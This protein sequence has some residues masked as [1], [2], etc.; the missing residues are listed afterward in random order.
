MNDPVTPVCTIMPALRAP[1]LR[2][3]PEDN[4]WAGAAPES[5]ACFRP[6]SS[7]HRPVTTLSLL[8][9]ADR[10]YGLFQVR[11]RY[12]RSVVTEFMGSVC[13]DSCVEFFVAP[14]PD[15]GYLNFEFNAGG[16][17]LVSHIRDPRRDPAGNGFADWRPLSPD[18]GARVAIAASLP[19]VV[20]PE[21]T[22]PVDWWL[23]FAIPFDLLQDV[24][25]APR[26][27]NTPP[28]RANFYKCG[29]RT[30]HP[31]WASWAPIKERNFHRPDDFGILR[32]S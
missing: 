19:A 26:P 8:H 1:V 29:D 5:I 4:A 9:D 25:G 31:H 28:W 22:D 16:T 15:T 11:D 21:R 30:S 20:E 23:A 13:T 2:C 14:G 3:G 27:C 12:V 32:F 17:L 18:E 6:E 24:A 10:L 7:D